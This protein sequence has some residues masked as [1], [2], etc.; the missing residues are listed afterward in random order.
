MTVQP[1]ERLRP[2]EDLTRAIDDHDIDVEALARWIHPTRG[3]VSP[4]EFV[5]VAEQSG[6]IPRIGSLVLDR[7]LS[8]L[9]A[10]QD[11]PVTIAARPRTRS[12]GQRPYQ[13]PRTNPVPSA[14]PDGQ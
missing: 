7:T 11:A 12:P 8:A 13:Q 4:S 14:A 10:W 1:H 6:Q 9:R 3:V 2:A 5:P